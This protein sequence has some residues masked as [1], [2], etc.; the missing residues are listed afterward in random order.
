MLIVTAKV[1]RRKLAVSVAAAALLCCAALVTT[2][3][4]P[5]AR[6][7]SAVGP[8]IK[9]VKTNENR[10]A[11]LEHYGWKVS[12][13]P[14]ATEELQIP[15]VFD[16]SYAEYLALQSSQGFDLKQYAGKRAK[17]YSYEIFNY[18]TGESGV[19]AN[20]LIYK[21]TVIG[22]EVLSPRLDGFLHGLSMP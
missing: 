13:E 16:E 4:P 11:Y 12:E 7:T 6:Q 18:P 2:L 17:R 14:S 10:V 22:G 3:V 1:P 21:N 19:I 5:A 15:E 20:L 9:K 8:D